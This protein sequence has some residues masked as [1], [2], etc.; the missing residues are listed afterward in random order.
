MVDSRAGTPRIA[1][2]PDLD[3]ILKPLLDALQG[4]DGVLVNDSQIQEICCR[5]IDW[6]LRD[7]HLVLR[8]HYLKDEWVCKKGLVFVQVTP[9]LCMPINVQQP[10][11]GLMAVLDVWGHQFAAKARFLASGM[12]YRFA[13]S[14][15]PQ[16]RP[17]H[18]SRLR[19]FGTVPLERLR[20]E[21]KSKKYI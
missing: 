7:Q 3:N 5:W 19:E 17:F 1:R 13:N 18:I 16:Q 12:D 11:K 9:T 21:L 20:R 10:A 14:A 8:I 2:S 15:T 4:P 6:E